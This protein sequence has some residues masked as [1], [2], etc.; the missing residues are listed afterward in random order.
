MTSKYFSLIKQERVTPETIEKFRSQFIFPD[1][2]TSIGIEFGEH[3]CTHKCRMCPQ[4]SIPNR[5]DQFI[6]EQTYQRILDR[7][8]CS[9]KVNLELSSYGETLLHPQAVC[10]ASLSRKRLPLA[11]IT[12]ATNG[13]LMDENVSKQLLEAEIDQIQVSLNTGSRESYRW[14]CGSDAYD[15]VVNNL[16]RLIALRNIYR[17]KTE[18]VTH[19]IGVREL[20]HEYENFISR[21]KGKVD[22]V[23]IRGYGNWGGKVDGNGL[24][25]IH[26]L[27]AERYPCVSLFGSLEILANGLAYKCYLH[28]IPG[29]QTSGIVGNVLEQDIRTIW[30]GP[31][32][33]R[34][35]SYHLRGEY[36]KIAF[37]RDCIGWGLVPNIWH[38]A[39]RPHEQL[40]H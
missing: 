12:F 8:D 17:A 7:I 13:F 34:I 3:G 32:M 22:Q 36:H 16:E 31:E 40:W 4:F 38:R 33:E 14:F 15:Q 19:I 26:P 1:Y 2:P 23:Y 24:T 28:G 39:Q 27:P 20:Q 5:D 30:T 10:L 11:K 18:I 37:C 6:S 29:A 21:W 25:S 9:R 35:R